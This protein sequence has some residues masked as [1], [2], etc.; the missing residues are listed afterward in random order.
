VTIHIVYRDPEEESV[1]GRLARALRDAG[2]WSL[3]PDPDR[4]AAVNMFTSY[5]DMAERFPDWHKSPVAAYFSHR[6][7]DNPSKVQLWENAARSVDLRIVTAPM[8]A[9]M[10][11]ATGPVALCRPPVDSQFSPRQVVRHEVPVLG[12]AGFVRARSARKGAALVREMLKRMDGRVRIVAIGDGWPMTCR[13]LPWG[14]LP[15]WYA[16]LDAYLC[17]STIEGIPMPPL[18]ALAMGISVIIP[19]GVGLLDSLP[20]DVPG[21][22]RY[23][24]GDA[25]SLARTLEQFR[26]TGRPPNP[27]RLRA[28]VMGFTAENWMRD[29]MAAFKLFDAVTD[30]EQEADEWLLTASAVDRTVGTCAEVP[31]VS[32]VARATPRRGMY[33]VAFGEPARD[34]AAKAVAAFRKYMPADVQIAVASD[35]PLKGADLHIATEDADVGG[36][37]VKTRMYD[38][39]PAEWDQV[40]YLDADTEVTKPDAAWLFRPLDDGWDM[41]ICTNP[42]KFHTARRMRRPD[43]EAECQATFAVMGTEEMVQFNG[44]VL[45]F[46]RNERTKAFFAA[47]HEEWQR[48]GKRDQAALLRALWRCPVRLFVVGNQFNCVLPYCPSDPNWNAGVMHHVLSVRRWTGTIE[49]RSDSK[50]AWG[51]VE[52]FKARGGKRADYKRR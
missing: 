44:G 21:I 39:A 23:D 13:R 28:C 25:R 49:D 48:W 40:L 22:W 50:E 31:T 43:N 34:G 18:E 52:L 4:G 36:R 1:L 38:L 12:V 29:H 11:S 47:W 26:G 20:G 10:L 9:D 32:H 37:S 24:A 15:A 46:R 35:R 33:M 7:D 2:V 42:G 19:R 14:E 6:E 3:S 8:Y 27:E 45:A 16:G 41:V 17:T 51:R 30:D 5:I